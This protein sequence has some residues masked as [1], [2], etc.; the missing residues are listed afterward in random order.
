MQH[1]RHR[2]RP[3]PRGRALRAIHRRHQLERGA[4]RPRRRRP[5]R[6]RAAISAL[7]D[8]ARPHAGLPLR[9]ARALPP[10]TSRVLTATRRARPV[11]RSPPRTRLNPISTQVTAATETSSSR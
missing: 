3:C 2:G 4:D 1:R 5:A 6:Q 7:I 11:P 8:G 10:S 9:R